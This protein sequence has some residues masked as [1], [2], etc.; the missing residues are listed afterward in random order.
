[1]ELEGWKFTLAVCAVIELLQQ[2]EFLEL[3]F[4]KTVNFF[5][6]SSTC[7]F[8]GCAALFKPVKLKC[9]IDFDP[10]QTLLEHRETR[11]RENITK[12]SELEK[13]TDTPQY[14]VLSPDEIKSAK[15]DLKSQLQ[16]R[17]VSE[18]IVVDN[19]PNIKPIYKAKPVQSLD[20]GMIKNFNWLMVTANLVMTQF[21]YSACLIHL[22]PRIQTVMEGNNNNSCECQFKNSTIPTCE[23]SSGENFSKSTL[24]M[25]VGICEILSQL[26]S[27][28][29]E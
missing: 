4:I 21:A 19:F 24:M 16:T 5:V 18:S 7:L 22:T 3:E 27:A 2:V 28:T 26:A 29:I 8:L 20:F 10:K 9:E 15:N 13:L 6:F 23:N 17:G 12:E 25:I 14:A 1:M 11:I